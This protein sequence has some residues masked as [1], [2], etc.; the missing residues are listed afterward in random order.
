MGI[1]R[2]AAMRMRQAWRSIIVTMISMLSPIMIVSPTFLERT[3]ISYFLAGASIL[4]FLIGDSDDFRLDW[5]GHDLPIVS[6]ER[7]DND[8]E[9]AAEP[10]IIREE[11]LC[12]R[13][14]WE[15]KFAM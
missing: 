12:C 15:P 13:L 11:L 8:H 5:V 10:G 9:C 6:A 7:G 14:C 4:G 3:S 2:G 1:S